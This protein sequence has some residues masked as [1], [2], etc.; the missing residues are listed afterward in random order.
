MNDK[1]TSVFPWSAKANRRQSKHHIFA[2]LR[3]R[4][5]KII[6]HHLRSQCEE[7]VHAETFDA[8]GESG[9]LLF[10][11]T[12]EGIGTASPLPERNTPA[13]PRLRANQFFGSAGD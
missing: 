2:P 9:W 5:N 10:S 6:R 13:S 12:A 1:P 7:F 4:V 11:L 8:M 3:L